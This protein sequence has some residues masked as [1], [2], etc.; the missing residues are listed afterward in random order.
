MTQESSFVCLE[1]KKGDFIA[2]NVVSRNVMV[3]PGGG[4]PMNMIVRN[5]ALHSPCVSILVYNPEKDSVFIGREYRSGVNEFRYG[6]AAGFIDEGETPD[7]AA[8]REV[9]E[10]LGFD[11]KEGSD[12]LIHLSTISSSEGFTNEEVYVYAYI[13]TQEPGETS[14]DSDEYVELTELKFDKFMEMVLSGEIKSAPTVVGAL[15][16]T[17]SPKGEL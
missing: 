12:S 17:M 10:E 15:R 6:N 2:F 7:I 9:K 1:Q 16:F 3:S 4:K 14:F 13:T 11:F 5:V 8:K